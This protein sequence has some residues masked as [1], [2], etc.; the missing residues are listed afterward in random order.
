MTDR[1]A[2]EA[3][4]S[5]LAGE[6][7]D[8]V[9]RNLFRWTA[10]LVGIEGAALYISDGAHL[11]VH[12]AYEMSPETVRPGAHLA[13]DAEGPAQE[14]LRQG[15]TQ[16]W[17]AD[18]GTAAPDN[19]MVAVHVPL[20]VAGRPIGVYSAGWKAPYRINPETILVLEGAASLAASA[21]HRAGLLHDIKR[22]EQRLRMLLDGLPLPAL[23]FSTANR[24]ITGLNAKARTM[25]GDVIGSPLSDVIDDLPSEG[26]VR[27]DTPESDHLTG[28]ARVRSIAGPTRVVV[29]HIAH[30]SRGLGV[31]MLVDVTQTANLDAQRGRF[32]R[33]VNHHLRTPLTPLMG[34]TQIIAQHAATDGLIAEAADQI[35]AA[36]EELVG[37]VTRLE[38]ISRLEPIHPSEI[39]VVDVGTL[40]ESGFDASPGDRRELSVH[41]DPGVRVACS[42]DNVIAAMFEVFANAYDHGRPPIT[43]SIIEQPSSVE[44]SVRDSGPGVPA[45]WG[46][47]L[48]AP[49]ASAGEGYLAPPQGHLGLGLTLARGLMEATGGSLRHV[50]GRFAFRLPPAR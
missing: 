15:V 34:Y 37:H 2:W 30:L 5:H 29:P 1:E 41:G 14:A 45:E 6:D 18:H 27:P 17:R 50:D 48:F 49:Y 26:A 24:V 23:E 10:S 13:V 43:L 12:A 44:I 9:A 46:V 28:R 21:I 11:V 25:L 35:S 39:R 8:E 16:V 36:V 47:G 3:G 32:V 42:P 33:M 20:V 7:P 31:L 19:W 38:Q 40:I 22:E 4:S